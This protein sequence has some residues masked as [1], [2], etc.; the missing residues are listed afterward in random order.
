MRVDFPISRELRFI[1]LACEGL[2]KKLFHDELRE[3][4]EQHERSL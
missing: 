1:S 4:V 2:E 3:A